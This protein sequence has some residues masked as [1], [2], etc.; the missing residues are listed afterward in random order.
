MNSRERI[1]ATLN[2]QEPDH[3]PLSFHF[4]FGF[5]APQKTLEWTDQFDR[6][7]KWNTHFGLDLPVRIRYP[8]SFHPDVKTR[9]WKETPA[10]ERYPLIY[11]DYETPAGT[12]R[13]VVSQTEDWPSGDKVSLMDDHNIPRSKEFPVKTEQDFEALRYLLCEPNK[14]KLR[15]FRE[16]FRRAKAFTRKHD[17]LFLGGTPA[18]GGDT[19]CW[20][21]GMQNLL[22]AAMD[23]PDFVDRLLGIINEW[24]VNLLT[25]LLEYDKDKDIDAIERR[26]WYE[27]TTLWSPELYKNLLAPRLKGCVDIAHQAEK[28]FVYYMSTGVMPLI[29]IFKDIG[30]DCLMNVDPVQ[31]GMDLTVLK[32][33]LGDRMSFWGGVNTSITINRGSKE[34]I[35]KAVEDAVMTLGP[36]GGFILEPIDGLYQD[37]PWENVKIFMDA[38]R[39]V[40][41]YPIS[42]G[43]G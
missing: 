7:N 19:A 9:T 5:K 34:D 24:E 21:Y 31:G 35:E 14:E 26:A 15:T 8:F 23:N 1:L 40:S 37:T 38:W 42:R 17:L 32:K 25:R 3:V 30:F 6:I 20:L 28:K 12:L 18:G 11:K 22:V 16:N 39:R 41:K 27:S 13:Q 36:G 4:S 10:G 33:E 2:L 43:A 29:N